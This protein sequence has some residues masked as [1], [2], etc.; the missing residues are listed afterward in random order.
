ME[1]FGIMGVA[2]ITVVCYLVATLVKAMP[3]DNKWIP[4]ICGGCGAILGVIG[5]YVMPD[6]PAYDI[7][8]ALAVGVTS[9][10]AATGVNQAYKQLTKDN[11]N[12]S[13]DA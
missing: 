9:G 8:T 1:T 11:D 6:F 5:F 3:L 7:V 13:E 12:G 10:F 4:V 2:A